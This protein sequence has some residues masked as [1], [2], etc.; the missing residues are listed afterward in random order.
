[1]SCNNHNLSIGDINGEGDLDLL[2]AEMF[3]EV[4]AYFNK[5]EGTFSK[6]TVSTAGAQ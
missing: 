2:G 4:A 3:G 6:Q 1:M 5:G